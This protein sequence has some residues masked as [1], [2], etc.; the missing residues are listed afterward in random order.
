M[1]EEDLFIKVSDFVK[2]KNWTAKTVY[3][4]VRKGLIPSCKNESGE[5]LINSKVAN[6]LYSFQNRILGEI[7][8]VVTKETICVRYGEMAKLCRE[9]NLPTDVFFWLINRKSTICQNRYILPENKHLIFTIIDLD[10]KKEY[11]CLNGMT[12]AYY[13]PN[14]ECHRPYLG[15][16]ISSLKINL[17]TIRSV[18]GRIFYLKGSNP[19]SRKNFGCMKVENSPTLQDSLKKKA[20]QKKLAQKIRGIIVRSLKAKNSNINYLFVENLGCSISEAKQYLES[21]FLEGMSWNNHGLRGWHIDHI[22]PCHSF[23]LTNPEERKKCFHYTNLQPL[24]ALDNM[25]KGNKSWKQ[26]AGGSNSDLHIENVR[27]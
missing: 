21:L 3:L 12:L 23:D 18:F 7:Y 9:R 17:R 15:S 20:H 25:K 5:I 4:N 6:D 26:S 8:D 2:T 10:S 1:S 24:W 14:E 16:K 13:F 22:I 11:D 19:L 27:F